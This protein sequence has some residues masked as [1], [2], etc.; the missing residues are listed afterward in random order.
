MRAHR[1]R[2]AEQ[3][4]YDGYNWET[5]TFASMTSRV[6]PALAAR[7]KPVLLGETSTHDAEKAAWISAIIPP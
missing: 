6:Y 5:D 1:C 3:R 7:N 2:A 4:P